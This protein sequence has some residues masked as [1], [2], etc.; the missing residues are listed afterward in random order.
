MSKSTAARH[1]DDSIL[2]SDLMSSDIETEDYFDHDLSSSTKTLEDTK[3]SKKTSPN[4]SNAAAAIIA[5]IRKFGLKENPRRLT[6]LFKVQNSSYNDDDSSKVYSNQLPLQSD[7][8]KE[9]TTTTTTTNDAAAAT[10][11]ALP[12]ATNTISPPNP[13]LPSLVGGKSLK[14]LKTLAMKTTSALGAPNSSDMSENSDSDFEDHIAVKLEKLNSKI[15]ALNG[16][17]PTTNKSKQQTKVKNF[18]GNSDKNKKKTKRKSKKSGKGSTAEDSKDPVKPFVSQPPPPPLP[19]SEALQPSNTLVA[20]DTVIHDSKNTSNTA[21][22]IVDGEDEEEDIC[23]ICDFDCT[24]GTVLSPPKPPSTASFVAHPIP[25]PQTTE[26][27]STVGSKTKTSTITPA[28][29]DT[30]ISTTAGAVVVADKKKPSK[31]TK[32]PASTNTKSKS[33]AAKN[34]K[35]NR[36]MATSTAIVGKEKKPKA[37]RSNI[38]SPSQMVDT[39]DDDQINIT[40]LLTSDDE[41]DY[42]FQDFED[43]VGADVDDSDKDL[44]DE[45]EDY[46][47]QTLVQ[48]MNK[49]KHQRKSHRA[50][51]SHMKGPSKRHGKR[52][53]GSKKAVLAH[54]QKVN[55]AASDGDDDDDNDDSDDLSSLSSLDGFSTSSSKFSDDSDIDTRDK[56]VAVALGLTGNSGNGEFDEV[57]SQDYDDSDDEEN[58][59]DAFLRSYYFDHYTSSSSLSSESEDEDVGPIVKDGISVQGGDPDDDREEQLLQMHLDQMNVV[60]KAIN[61]DSDNGGNLTTAEALFESFG[62]IDCSDLSGNEN[63]RYNNN[64]SDDEAYQEMLAQSLAES[65][66]AGGSQSDVDSLVNVS[67]DF[68]WSDTEIDDDGDNEGHMGVDSISDDSDSSSDSSNYDGY[69]MLGDSLS[70]SYNLLLD[71]D[72]DE[73]DSVS[74]AL[75]IALSMENQKSGNNNSNGN[76]SQNNGGEDLPGSAVV[77]LEQGDVIGNPDDKDESDGNGVSTTVVTAGTNAQGVEEDPIDGHVTVVSTKP[78]SNRRKC[79]SNANLGATSSTQQE[80]QDELL[81]SIAAV[82]AASA[83]PE[84]MGSMAET[85]AIL[86]LIPPSTS[87]PSAFTSVTTTATATTITPINNDGFSMDMDDLPVPASNSQPTSQLLPNSSIYKP[88]SSLTTTPVRD[89]RSLKAMEAAGGSNVVDLPDSN[90]HE[91]TSAFASLAKMLESNDHSNNS[92]A[93]PSDSNIQCGLVAGNDIESQDLLPP[94]FSFFGNNSGNSSNNSSSNDKGTVGD[95]QQGGLTTSELESILNSPGFCR[96]SAAAASTSRSPTGYSSYCPMTPIQSP[97]PLKRKLEYSMPYTAPSTPVNGTSSNYNDGS[98]SAE[99]FITGNLV[100][101]FSSSADTGYV[102]SKNIHHRG[103]PAPTM[104]RRLSSPHLD[105]T[106]ISLDDILDSDAFACPSPP[107]QTPVGSSSVAEESDS[108]DEG[109]ELFIKST[110]MSANTSGINISDRCELGQ[111]KKQQQRHG[112]SKSI[113][114]CVDS[115]STSPTPKIKRRK[116]NE[117]AESVT[118]KGLDTMT[119]RASSSSSAITNSNI[120]GG[121]GGLYEST[122]KWDRIPINIFRRSRDLAGLRRYYETMMVSGSGGGNTSNAIKSNTRVGRAIV[123]SML[124]TQHTL[125]RAPHP[126]SLLSGKWNAGSDLDSFQKRLQRERRK[127]RR[128]ANSET[129]KVNRLLFGTSN[130]SNGRGN[131]IRNASSF[132]G[133]GGGSINEA[134]MLL[135]KLTMSGLDNSSQMDLNDNVGTSSDL[136]ATNGRDTSAKTNVSKNNSSSAKSSTPA[137]GKSGKHHQQSESSIRNNN[138]DEQQSGQNLGDERIG[139]DSVVDSSES[140]KDD[141]EDYMFEWVEDGQDLQLFSIPE[142]TTSGIF[143]HMDI[144]A[145]SIPIAS[146]SPLTSFGDVATATPPSITDDYLGGDGDDSTSNLSH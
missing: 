96:N 13:S 44:L 52:A 26:S 97:F 101:S 99:N 63:S 10:A 85:S 141:K 25:P 73:I 32:K 102:N 54:G 38:E 3:H 89:D 57:Y 15:P 43:V 146:N 87:I 41:N 93:K 140:T 27:N 145:M 125:G 136:G 144:S 35:N 92:P 104:V 4:K 91:I 1:D 37:N 2:E 138:N 90:T 31:N 112:K 83:V 114:G 59:E 48:R 61:K 55:S 66:N 71:L 58:D 142:F 130:M 135:T 100:G 6:K 115:T 121:R 119:L 62:Y 103:A 64:S 53:T 79:G 108:A 19:A 72:Q 65:A 82:A 70:N 106:Q 116:T 107:P 29:N 124:L 42:D 105:S 69:H 68:G 143:E 122:N 28:S 16:P 56:N 21:S 127:D 128:R 34:S 18:A 86:S 126:S 77:A 98:G 60:H 5:S 22:Q 134:H 7:G 74:L 36:P 24:C 133:G 76:Q 51:H 95:D 8:F 118:I 139:G 131:T 67:T 123:N 132:G 137:G 84:S 81:H 20:T 88:L 40:D 46:I 30:L 111:L 50:Q 45:E 14:S 78:R 49:K 113:A 39:D 80:R 117:A 110:T 120:A 9:A 109:D 11:A 75:G 12:K 47:K 33:K 94:S 23:P 17:V 129:R